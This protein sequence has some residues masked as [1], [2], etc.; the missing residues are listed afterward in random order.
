MVTPRVYELCKD[1][2]PYNDFKVVGTNTQKR[3]V[4]TREE[5][6]RHPVHP[7]DPEEIEWIEESKTIPRHYNSVI[8]DGTQYNV[9]ALP[10]SSKR[11]I[12]MF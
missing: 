7:E 1:L 4:L 11:L 9:C 10:D 8:I 6:R 5:K 3:I 12:D 2:Y